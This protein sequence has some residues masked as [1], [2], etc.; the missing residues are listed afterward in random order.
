[1]TGRALAAVAAC[2]ATLASAAPG[3][4]Q[5]LRQAG[6]VAAWESRTGQAIRFASEPPMNGPPK[7]TATGF[8]EQ[9]IYLFRYGS[10][11]RLYRLMGCQP[12][13][14]GARFAVWAPNAQAV[15]VVGEF[16]G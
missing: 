12:H 11:A 9:D 13:A 8:G 3:Q 2:A 1:M 4:W 5:I 10:H 6:F 14:E 16:N 7:S 15:S